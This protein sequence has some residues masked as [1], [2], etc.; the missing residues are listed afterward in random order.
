MRI[1]HERET[2]DEERDT[3]RVREVEGDG[4]TILTADLG[5]LGPGASLDVVEGTAIVVD[6][7]NSSADER[8]PSVGGG[9]GGDRQIEVDLPAGVTGADVTL[10]NGVLTVRR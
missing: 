5:P 3:V 4:E 2:A 10:N 1:P 9:G 7:R 8:A 6:G